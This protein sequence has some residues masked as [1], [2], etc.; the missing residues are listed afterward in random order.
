MSCLWTL[1][2]KK[3]GANPVILS[4]AKVENPLR[5]NE[6]PTTEIELRAFE[7]ALISNLVSL[8][9]SIE[10]TKK[11]VGIEFRNGRTD[12]ARALIAKNTHLLERKMLFENRL[13]RVQK[14]LAAL[15]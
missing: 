6:V 9:Y 10:E 11:K 3:K 14:N 7:E 2:W 12:R 13:E 1:C 8:H 5:L 4:D 15:R